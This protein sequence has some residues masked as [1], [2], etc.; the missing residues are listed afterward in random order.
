M[1]EHMCI[2]R[3]RAQNCALYTSV[4]FVVSVP[5]FAMCSRLFMLCVR[6][7][8]VCRSHLCIVNVREYEVQDTFPLQPPYPRPDPMREPP[9]NKKK[10][11]HKTCSV[12]TRMSGLSNPQMPDKCTSPPKRR[13]STTQ[14]NPKTKKKSLT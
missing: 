9:T 14:K 10:L 13:V 11:H 7:Y 12:G 8:A 3:R 5:L 6:M 2:N 4:C 1:C